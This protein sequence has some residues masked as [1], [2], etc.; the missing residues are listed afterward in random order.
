MQRSPCSSQAHTPI[1]RN[2]LCVRPT[3]L[4]EGVSS[5]A[6]EKNALGGGFVWERVA[7]IPARDKKEGGAAESDEPR[8]R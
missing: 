7:H 1:D 4:Q 5:R 8:E 3:V 2:E 6:Q